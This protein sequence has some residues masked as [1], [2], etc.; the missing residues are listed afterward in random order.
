MKLHNYIVKKSFFKNIFQK[1]TM[2][3][4]QRTVVITLERTENLEIKSI[5]ASK[6]PAELVAVDLTSRPH[7][8]ECDPDLKQHASLAR[9]FKYLYMYLSKSLYQQRKYP[10][11]SN[12]K[13]KSHSDSK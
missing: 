10:I 13:K 4:S 2:I 7:L 5:A 12:L 6:S 11:C 8:K 1:F 9:L 3:T